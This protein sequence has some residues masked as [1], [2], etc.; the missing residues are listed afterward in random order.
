MV[1]TL[2]RRRSPRTGDTEMRPSTQSRFPQDRKAAARALALRTIIEQAQAD[3]LAVAAATDLTVPR[4]QS[5]L[6]GSAVI[7][8]PLAMHLE[9]SLGLPPDCLDSG[10]PLTA[11]Q[12]REFTAR[13]QNPSATETSEPA[14]PQAANGA[15]TAAGP[16]KRRRKS[17]KPKAVDASQAA[18]SAA[19][20]PTV[21]SSPAAVAT[22]EQAAPGSMPSEQVLEVLRQA[23]RRGPVKRAKPSKQDKELIALRKGNLE[24]F[25]RSR[26]AK[27]FLADSL[28]VNPSRISLYLDRTPIPTEFARKAERALLLEEGWTDAVLDLPMLEQA[29]DHVAMVVAG[30]ADASLPLPPGAKVFKAGAA[31]HAA[32]PAVTSR[33]V[34]PTTASPRAAPTPAPSAATA[35]T[36]VPSLASAA[37][38]A[39]GAYSAEAEHVLRRLHN[40]LDIAFSKGALTPERAWELLDR[41][42]SILEMQIQLP[43]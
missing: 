24:S 4:L 22:Q 41:V 25:L 19:P 28:G 15:G 38:S 5:L 1:N 7:D 11:E 20:V 33:R 13:L 23:N 3:L 26:G 36:P 31:S 39:P 37:A 18:T 27:R 29:A 16:S 10:V 42:D 17:S 32:A 34:M 14:W 40:K 43:R 8:P 2:T 9:T 6:S 12:L 30:T 35:Q 21:S